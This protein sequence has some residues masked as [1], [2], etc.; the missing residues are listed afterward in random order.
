MSDNIMEYIP[1]LR[2]YARSLCGRAHDADDLVQETLLRAI[3]YADRYK[4]GSHMRAWLFTIM[5][6]RFYTTVKK[7][8]RE[9]TGGAD[10]V[11]GSP[12][13][14]PGQ[15]WY[16]R[17]REL[18]DQLER[19]PAHYREALVLVSVLGESYI[20]AAEV[21]DCD[22]GTVKSRVNRARGL[23]RKALEPEF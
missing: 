4:P 23:L 11:S 12:I 1:A 21:M 16:L 7:S 5:R 18:C 2:A 13:S 17:H 15:E 20:R 22:I 10:C 19:I 14:Q 8:A 3:E 9:R 6:N